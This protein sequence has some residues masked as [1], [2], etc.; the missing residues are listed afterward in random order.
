MAVIAI[1]KAG[2]ARTP[3]HSGITQCWVE[4]ERRKL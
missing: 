4:V 2:I 1:P 3:T